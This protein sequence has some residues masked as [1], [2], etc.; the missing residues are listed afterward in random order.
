MA[1]NVE[2]VIVFEEDHAQYDEFQGSTCPRTT[3]VFGWKCAVLPYVRNK[4]TLCHKNKVPVYHWTHHVNFT[5]RFTRGG[6]GAAAAD[7]RLLST[8]LD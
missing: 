1:P 5:T 7:H 3:F 2:K 6:P 4:L 8:E